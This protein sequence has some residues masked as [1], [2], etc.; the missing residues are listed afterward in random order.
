[1]VFIGIIVTML[2][3]A[4][5]LMQPSLLVQ[6]AQHP[7]IGFLAFFAPL[8]LAQRWHREFPRNI[9]L[10]LLA[11]FVCG[12]W[13]APILYYYNQ[14]QPG[15]VGQ[16]GVGQLLLYRTARPDRGVAAE[17]LFPQPDGVALA[18]GWNGARVRRPARLRY[19]ADRADESVRARGLRAR[20]GEHLCRST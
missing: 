7:F 3:A 17:S 15:V 9:A 13:I 12:V 16:A 8:F 18:R 4:F 14:T 6:S 20:G 11:M 1:L 19:V 5:A 10:T 2:G